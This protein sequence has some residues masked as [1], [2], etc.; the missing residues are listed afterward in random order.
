M[1]VVRTG[2]FAPA[3][4][5]WDVMW[6]SRGEP[7]RLRGS[8]YPLPDCMRGRQRLATRPERGEVQRGE[9]S[10]APFNFILDDQRG[11]SRSF[12]ADGRKT[13]A[14]RHHLGSLEGIASSL[15]TNGHGFPARSLGSGQLGG[16]RPKKQLSALINALNR[17]RQLNCACQMRCGSS[18][19]KSTC[20]LR[21][22]VNVDTVSSPKCC[23]CSSPSRTHNH[24]TNRRPSYLP[25]RSHQNSS[26][27]RFGGQL[28]ASLPP[29]VD[30]GGQFSTTVEPCHL[31]TRKR[32]KAPQTDQGTLSVSLCGGNVCVVH[33][34]PGRLEMRRKDRCPAVT[35]PSWV[36]HS[37]AAVLLG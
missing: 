3:G 29:L 9:Q 32:N 34:R 26:M 10:L 19:G 22:L 18:A 1:R 11:R 14:I 31:T 13:N 8:H 2:L 21:K 23:H 24:Y 37:G 28:R 17:L 4:G 25:H 27:P 15:F 33:C 20:G 30:G 35:S 5:L 6:T 16:L 36:V 12:F 7:Y